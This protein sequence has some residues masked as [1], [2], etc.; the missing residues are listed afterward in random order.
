MASQL[1]SAAGNHVSLPEIYVRPESQ[2]PR[3]HDVINDVNIP[4]ID[5][6]SP[7]RQQI[8]AQVADACRSFGFFQVR[9]CL[10]HGVAVDSMEKM[11]EVASEF[12]H[13]PPE[14]KAKYYSDDPTK[15]MKL[16][17]SF[18]IRKESVR[19]W[20]DYLR[21]HC[22]PLEEFVAGWPS[23]PASFK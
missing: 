3:L 5:L 11:M 15:K 17:T 6:G 18:N 4:V 7:D 21:L 10:N 16:S 1:L 8:V 2:R 13:L 14:E 22:Y 23:N 20:R 12:F 19:N 9:S